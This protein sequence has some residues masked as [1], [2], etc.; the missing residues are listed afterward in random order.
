MDCHH[1]KGHGVRGCGPTIPD[2]IHKCKNRTVVRPV[3]SLNLVHYSWSISSGFVQNRT[4][5][6]QYGMPCLPQSRAAASVAGTPVRTFLS[7]IPP[8]PP[9]VC[10]TLARLCRAPLEQILINT[11]SDPM[12]I[13][14]STSSVRTSSCKLL[15]R[16]GGLTD[17]YLLWS[18]WSR[19][20]ESLHVLFDSGEY[21]SP[22]STNVRTKAVQRICRKWTRCGS[23]HPICDTRMSGTYGGREKLISWDDRPIPAWGRG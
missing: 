15:P 17:T 18:V 6:E 19:G 1:A 5:K 12:H 10:C 21:L 9:P 4:M 13:E 20:F 14:E 23:A 11:K 8:P 16:R 3:V 7:D 22:I 2:A